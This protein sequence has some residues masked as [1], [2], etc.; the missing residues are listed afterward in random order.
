MFG[1]TEYI[2]GNILTG[3]P[4]NLIVYSFS[5]NINFISFLSIIGTYSFNLLAI[6]FFTAPAVYILKKIQKR[7]FSIYYIIIISNFIFFAYGISYKNFFLSKEPSKN[8]YTIRVL[9][10]NISLDRFYEKT[11]TE[12]VMNELIKLSA[13]NLDKKIFFLWPEGIIP[14]TYLDQLTLFSDLFKKNFKKII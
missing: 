14:D 3:F 4:W 10:S 9:S 6:S 1:L 12:I 5:E 13:P 7:N 11:E 2:R 8:P